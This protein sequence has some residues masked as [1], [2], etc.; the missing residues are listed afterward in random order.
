MFSVLWV[1]LG[2]LIQIP[3]DNRKFSADTLFVSVA[4]IQTLRL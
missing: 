2:E 1:L 3:D 4:D